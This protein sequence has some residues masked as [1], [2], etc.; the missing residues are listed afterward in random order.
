MPHEIYNFI[1]FR[2]FDA[3]ITNFANKMIDNTEKHC[4]EECT[5]NLKEAPFNYQNAH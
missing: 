3:C 4:V 5:S 1:L 2:C